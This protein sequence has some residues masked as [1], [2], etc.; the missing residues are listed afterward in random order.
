MTGPLAPEGWRRL[1]ADLLP[2]TPRHPVAQYTLGEYA[3]LRE[4]QG[5]ERADEAFP[6]LAKHLEEGCRDC[7]AQLGTLGGFAA[8][9][10]R[11]SD[12]LNRYQAAHDYREGLERDTAETRELR[13]Y[14][15]RRWDSG[16][17]ADVALLDRISRRHLRVLLSEQ[18]SITDLE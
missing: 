11:I 1:W 2:E 15:Q 18:E 16:L 14:Q 5:I 8:T 10:H 13:R 17:L 6:D 12:S 7:R 4:R 9:V 3:V